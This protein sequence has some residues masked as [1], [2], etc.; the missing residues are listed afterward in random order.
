VNLGFL[1]TRKGYLKVLGAVVQ[2]AL[3]RGHHVTL[4]WDPLETKAGERMRPEDLGAWPH[5]VAR[6]WERGTPLLPAL[7]A[8]GIESLIGTKIDYVLSAYGYQAELTALAPAGIRLFSID[9]LFDTITLEPESYRRVDTTFYLSE[10]QRDLHWRV[11]AEGFARLGD[12]AAWR[13]RSAVCG[14]TMM[15]QLAR[16]DS[17]AVRRRYGLAPDQPVVVFM[18]LKMAVP[19]AWRRAV[20]G[21]QPRLLRAARA[22]VS[23]HFEW[24]PE[25]LRTHGYRDL[26][27]SVRAFCQRAGAALVVKSREK[28]DDPAFLR[29]LADV[30]L[31]DEQV[32][33]YTSME[34]MAIASLCI[35]FQSGA[36]LEAAFA[37]VPSLSVAVPQSHLAAYPTYDE[38]YSARPGSMQNFPGVVWSL[39]V[40]EV[41]GRLER[42]RLPD[43]SLDLAARRHYVEKFLGFDDTRSSERVLD[44]IE[45]VGATAPAAA[46]S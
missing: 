6:R 42:A 19:E 39:P 34:L 16:V 11:K 37:G 28:N 40:A 21:S 4:L 44:E 12:M 38:A 1:V 22:A 15:D 26:V 30:S 24:I 17:A 5:A 29:D 33:P 46:R 31:S 35:H 18:S 20:W 10:Y 7:Q 2:A 9:Y 32:Y 41:A 3:A 36:V 45:R 43:F 8:A 23:G 13:A 14:S 27:E 25:I